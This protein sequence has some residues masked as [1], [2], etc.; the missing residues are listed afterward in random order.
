MEAQPELVKRHRTRS[1]VLDYSVGAYFL[2]ICTHEHRCYFGKVQDDKVVLN[3]IGKIVFDD[4]LQSLAVR[5]ELIFDIY[6]VMPNHIHLVVALNRDVS[7]AES[8]RFES[9]SKNIGAFVRAFKAMSTKHVRDRINK[10]DFQVW[11]RNYYDHRIRNEYDYGNIQRYIAENPLR[12]TLDQENPDL[13]RK[14]V[15]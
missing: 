5:S 2:T 11:Q 7:V 12:W 1:T 13:I 14:K 8:K 4:L 9:P 3:W 15:K 10:H 6:V